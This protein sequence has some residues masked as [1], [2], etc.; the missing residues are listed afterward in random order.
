MKNSTKRLLKQFN[1][2]SM[3]KNQTIKMLNELKRKKEGK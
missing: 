2:E 3:E 1:A